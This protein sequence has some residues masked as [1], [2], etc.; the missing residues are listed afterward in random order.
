MSIE[1]EEL[2]T[3]IAEDE[4]LSEALGAVE[5]ILRTLGDLAPDG[6]GLCSQ[7]SWGFRIGGRPAFLLED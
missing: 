4:V 1:R 7:L 3:I 2:R 6:T 5:P